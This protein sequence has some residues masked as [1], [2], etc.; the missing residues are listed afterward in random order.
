MPK[1]R[2]EILLLSLLLMLF[3]TI[4]QAAE[5]GAEPA[6]KVPAYVSLGKPMVLNL[7]T[8][9]RRLAFLQISADVLVKDDT[10]KTVVEANIPAIRNQL[11]LMLSEQNAADMKTP[12][13]REEI[14]KK[15]STAVRDLIEKMTDNNDIDEVLFSSFLVQ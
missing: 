3:S 7:A 11:I 13:K 9:G 2:I 5:D 6:K 1:T 15:V 10:A 4:A 12:A 14:R 8:D